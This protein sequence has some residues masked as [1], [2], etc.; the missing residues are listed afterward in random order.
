MG[1]PLGLWDL[2]LEE[3]LVAPFVAQFE[4]PPTTTS[5]VGRQT[6]ICTRHTQNDSFLTSCAPGAMEKWV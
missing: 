5:E 1:T 2:N 3:S 4:E 6:A